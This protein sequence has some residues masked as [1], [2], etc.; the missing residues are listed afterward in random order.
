[1]A[2]LLLANKADVNATDSWLHTPLHF[3][4]AV[5]QQ[6][7]GGIAAPAWRARELSK[8]RV[9]QKAPVFTHENIGLFAAIPG[10]A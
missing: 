5:W 1:M 2:E 8:E 7:R 10:V 9:V 6:E 4:G 3:A